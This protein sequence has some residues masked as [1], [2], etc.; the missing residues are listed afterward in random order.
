[1]TITYSKAFEPT[2]LTTSAATLFTVATLP[3]S[4]LLRGGRVRFSNTTAGPITV[5]AYAVPLSGTAA[6]GNA[7]TSA[8]SIAANDYLDI[9]L[10]VMKAGDFFQ[11]LASA[12]TSITAHY[13]SGS[14]FS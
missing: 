6:V 1:M 5:T 4:N 2:V 12:N 14:T 11:A 9:D 3:T 10:P 13:L 7:I 8:K